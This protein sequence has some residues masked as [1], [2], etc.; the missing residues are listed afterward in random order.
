[1]VQIHK[2]FIDDQVKELFE[3]YLQK[4]IE[5]KHIQEILCIKK[6]RF[7]VLLRQYRTNPKNFS[8]QYIRK[9][10]VRFIDPL[11]EENIIKELS[12]DKNAISNKDIPLKSYNYSYVKDRLETKYNQIVS[13]PTIIDRAKKNDFYL[14][15]KSPKTIHD[16]EVLTN[17]AGELIQHDSSYHLWSPAAQEKW[18]L[19]TSLDDFSRFIL[20]AVLLKRE[21]SWTHILALQTVIL[22]YGCPFKYYVDSHSIF[23]FVQNRDSIWR[24][25]YLLTDESTPQWKQVLED[26]NVKVSY[27]LSPQAKGKIER[28]YGWLQDR[29]VRTCVRENVTDIKQAQR[30]LTY[31][32]QR[33]NYRQVHST[34]QEVPYLRFQNAINENRSLFRQ[35]K[36]M[37][38]YQSP[39]DIFCLRIN[40]TVD[41]YRK[42]SINNLQLKVNNAVPRETVTLRIYPL[43]NFVSEIRFWCNDKLL[44]VQKIKIS[45][46]KGVH[47]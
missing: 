13:L 16:R 26:C 12:I 34:T 44:D 14:P 38:P 29:L 3:R 21:T 15:K 35:F 32:I 46:L 45:D 31:E 4:K 17:Y 19:I 47:F 11:I 10:K 40:R 8:I 2:K 43:N 6:R 30:I 39:K 22:K 33:Y 24:N 28:P 23:R 7:F 5:R 20:Y 18:W 1:M 36:V 42:I 27:A 41:A 25:H 9:S 37:P